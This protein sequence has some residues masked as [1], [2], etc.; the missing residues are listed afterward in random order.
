MDYFDRNNNVLSEKWQDDQAGFYK[1]FARSGEVWAQFK[2]Y[3]QHEGFTLVA[4]ADTAIAHQFS[5]DDVVEARTT[6]EA[7]M[8]A[9]A[10][11]RLWGIAAWY[12]AIQEVDRTLQASLELWDKAEALAR[13]EISANE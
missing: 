4:E 8:R 6:I 5:V 11:R 13:R 7:R 1:T 2:S 10:A 12:P 9:Y 3:I